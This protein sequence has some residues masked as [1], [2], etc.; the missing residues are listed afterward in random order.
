MVKKCKVSDLAKDLNIKAKELIEVLEQYTDGQKKT[1]T[2]LTEEEINIALEI[3]SQ[4]MP[5]V[6]Q[7][8]VCIF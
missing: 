6:S 4:N 2:I 8:Y 1:S 7:K 5:F 3:Y